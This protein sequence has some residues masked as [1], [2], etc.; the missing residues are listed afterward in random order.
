MNVTHESEANTHS[1]HL[2]ISDLRFNVSSRKFPL[3]LEYDTTY[4]QFLITQAKPSALT[5]DVSLLLKE[6]LPDISHLTRIF[7]TPE[8]WYM[9]YG[10]S[11]KFIVFQPPNDPERDP[12]WIARIDPDLH[13]VDV[14]CEK[15]ELGGSPEKQII[16][17]PVRYPLDQILLINCL[18]GKGL[19][20]H[21]AG[22]TINGKGF[23]FAGI[24]GAGKS[25]ICSLFQDSG[26]NTI[27]SDDRMVVRKSRHDF[28]MYGTPWA[29]DAGI[30]VNE[31]EALQGV[32]FLKHSSENR[33]RKLT[34]EE[35]LD[36]FFKVASLPW[37][38]KKDLQRSLDFCDD[39]L[40][41]IKMYELN[42]RHE[43]GIVKNIISFV[44]G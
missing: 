40:K 19:L 10:S 23:L 15:K 6:E 39:L 20:I 36:K 2:S 7:E 29:G 8:S 18:L 30:A 13:H 24:S 9:L 42:F 12:A 5:V 3:F 25:T 35:S 32:F 16:D 22:I 4:K 33:I 14:Y 41:E 21:A 28:L 37:Y 44:S 26:V 38:D 43:P 34:P 1:I 11:G 31:S 17:N 27:L